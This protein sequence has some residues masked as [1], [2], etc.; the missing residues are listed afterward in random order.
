[1]G[2]PLKKGLH[3]FN[4][5]C[6]QEANLS[7]IE[8]KHGLIGFAIVVKLWQKIYAFEGYFYVWNEQNICLFAREFNVQI[9]LINE[10]VETCFKEDIFDRQL[11]TEFTIL[12]GRGIQKRYIKICIEAKR[13]GFEVDSKYL[14]SNVT[15]CKKELL[16]VITTPD[17]QL[18]GGFSTQ[19]KVKE[20]KVKESKTALRV[21]I[22][23]KEE[24]L[25]TALPLAGKN[26]ISDHKKTKNNVPEPYWQLIVKTWF[27]FGK[28][29]FG[30]SPSFQSKETA[31]LK[32]IIGLLKKRAAMKNIEWDEKNAIQ[33]F[34]LFLESAFKIDWLSKNF[35]L[36]NLEKQFDKI[37]QN[38][39]SLK[40]ANH[41]VSSQ[42]IE[43]LFE[44]F[45]ENDLDYKYI[46]ASHYTEL[47]NNKLISDE[48]KKYVRQKRENQLHGTNHA[49]EL[50]LLRAY[51]SKK[52]TPETIN[53][54]INL[55]RMAVI[56]VFKK[57]KS[58][59]AKKTIGVEQT[60]LTG[61]AI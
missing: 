37:I 14:I 13:R 30:E 2:R 4:V 20:S 61:I 29:K 41:P 28:E 3:Y 32:R 34:R 11:F 21:N 38:Q 49:S 56:E 23:G 55:M 16:E 6:F 31:T 44:R 36:S 5:D 52:E 25:P 35:L 17:Q 59:D 43:Y 24:L 48:I 39:N 22:T 45:C 58:E 18:L 1:M 19:S 8:A 54:K 42:S 57:R 50:K 12:T 27:D 9:N 26:G 47:D 15:Y 10:V 51:Q 60:A 53:D 46:D 40:K 7:F 33:R